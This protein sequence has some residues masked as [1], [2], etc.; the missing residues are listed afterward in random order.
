MSAAPKKDLAD[1]E[2]TRDGTPRPR[3]D[4]V[5]GLS[6]TRTQ[7]TFTTGIVEAPVCRTAAMTVEYSHRH[8]L[9]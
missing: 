6:S 9:S 2:A 7:R 3:N 4:F 5:L 8:S 1:L